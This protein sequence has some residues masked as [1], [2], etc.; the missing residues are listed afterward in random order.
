VRNVVP[1]SPAW[2]AGLTFGDEVVAVDDMRV[3]GTSVAR[4]FSD[5]GPRDEVRVA[6]FR[7]DT[8]RTATVVLAESPERQWEFSLAFN[9]SPRVR[10]VRRGWLGT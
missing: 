1:G 7:Q 4:R 9:V 10:A 5:A 8:L 3:N 6:F 2:R